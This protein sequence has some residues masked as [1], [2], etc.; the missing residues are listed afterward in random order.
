MSF[1]DKYVEAA[2]RVQKQRQAQREKSE[3]NAAKLRPTTNPHLP[4][5]PRAGKK[6]E[7]RRD[8]VHPLLHPYRAASDTPL[9][10]QMRRIDT[11][12]AYRSHAEEQV[13]QHREAAAKERERLSAPHPL[14]KFSH[15][16]IPER[17]PV[18]KR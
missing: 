14:L 16:P 3:A 18:R 6:V 12:L 4:P 17:K 9:E 13:R 15:M 7:E 10:V 11:H 2:E 1:I 8:H 5:M